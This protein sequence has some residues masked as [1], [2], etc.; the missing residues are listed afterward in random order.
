MLSSFKRG[1]GRPRGERSP[2]SSPYTALLSSPV[3]A[4]RG[5]LEERR[6]PAADFNADVSPARDTKVDEHEDEEELE[7]EDE[8]D[9]D[10][11]GEGDTTPLLPIFSA[12]HLGIHV[13]HTTSTNMPITIADHPRFPSCIQ[14]DT[15]HPLTGRSA[16]RNHP[17]MG[18]IEV[19]AGL[20][21][22]GEAHSAADPNF[23]F[24]PCDAVRPDGQLPTVQQGGA[25]ESRE[26]RCK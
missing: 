3:A 23:S 20:S 18:P 2:F 21:V 12:A 9:E 26:Q 22:S 8:E 1:R 4:R 6:R 15:R 14:P 25:N 11:D 16:M 17:L 13:V 5:S 7:E 10:E 19:S 24:L